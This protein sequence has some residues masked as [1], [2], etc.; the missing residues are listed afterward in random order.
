MLAILSIA[1]QTSSSLLLIPPSSQSSSHR[2][3]ATTAALRIPSSIFLQTA[4]SSP[5]SG[6]TRTSL[7]FARSSKSV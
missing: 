5:L 4:Q 1:E 6:D 2:R 7:P 3:S